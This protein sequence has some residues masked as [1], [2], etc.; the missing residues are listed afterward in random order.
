MTPFATNRA[1][2]SS[3]FARKLDGFSALSGTPEIA[4]RLR[5]YI[6]RSAALLDGCATPR[7]CHYDFHPGN[8][9]AGRQD[10]TLRLTGLVDL[11]N[12]IAGDPLMDVAKTLN[13]SAHGVA[14]RRAGLLA[15]YGPIERPHWE[16][17]VALYELSGLLEPWCWW[18]QIGDHEHADGIMADFA[19]FA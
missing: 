19:G 6:G 12:A 1:Y 4:A 5:D 7:L 18:T 14:A 15:G 16:D 17:T 8:V 2:M 9:L 10:G 3:Q 13:C 11:E